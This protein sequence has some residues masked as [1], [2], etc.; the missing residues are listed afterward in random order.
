MPTD[1]PFDLAPYQLHRWQEHGSLLVLVP[2][3]R[4]P[5]EY[6]PGRWDWD[7]TSPATAIRGGTLEELTGRLREGCPYCPG[8]RL[9]VTEELADPASARVRAEWTRTHRFPIADCDCKRVQELT[10]TEWTR[11]GISLGGF[12][13]SMTAQARED[14]NVRYVHRPELAWERNPWVWI[15]SCEAAEA[16]GGR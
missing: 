9:V 7:G 10:T 5:S 3:G 4:Q 12:D 1:Y 2:M 14:W 8:D 16:A 13:I 15:L 11:A 6:L